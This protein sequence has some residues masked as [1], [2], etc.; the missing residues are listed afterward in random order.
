MKLMRAL[1]YQS[2]THIE[3]SKAAGKSSAEDSG[4]SPEGGIGNTNKTFY[5]EPLQAICLDVHNQSAPVPEPLENNRT[6]R[7]TELLKA[8]QENMT[9]K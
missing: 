6:G 2:E 3:N 7:M 8:L 4:L 1:H 9:E 5:L